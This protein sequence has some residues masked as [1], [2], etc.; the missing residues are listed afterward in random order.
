MVSNKWMSSGSRLYWF[1][2]N[3]AMATGWRFVDGAWRLFGDDGALI[4]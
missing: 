1:D 3:G 4:Y 2:G